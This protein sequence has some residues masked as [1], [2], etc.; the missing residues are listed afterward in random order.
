M[1]VISILVIK[2]FTKEWLITGS[3]I[4]AVNVLKVDHSMG[5][6]QGRWDHEPANKV[7]GALQS[8]NKQTISTV[9]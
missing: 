4:I 6:L 7:A 3:I 9:S 5:H 2:A 8:N 1:G